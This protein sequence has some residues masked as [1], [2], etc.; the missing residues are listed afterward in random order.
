MGF[1]QAD[2]PALHGLDER[3]RLPRILRRRLEAWPIKLDHRL[4]FGRSP[5]CGCNP[6]AY[7]RTCR[8]VEQP[9]DLDDGPDAQLSLA[10][11]GGGGPLATHRFPG[12]ADEEFLERGILHV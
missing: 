2:V 1:R 11:C 12:E 7:P 8:S 5:R 9:V 3:A 10:V 6:E 4:H